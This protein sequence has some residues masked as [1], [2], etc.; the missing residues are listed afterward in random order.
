MRKKSITVLIKIRSWI[1]SLIVVIFIVYLT[2]ATVRSVK[3][4]ILFLKKDRIN[5]VFYGKQTV[6]LS[7][8]LTD[9]VHYQIPFANNLLL[10]IPG[11]YG[12]YKVGSLGKLSQ[13]EKNPTLIQ[14]TFSSATASFVDFDFFPKKTEIYSTNQS[15]V[16]INTLLQLLFSP[17]YQS[18]ASFFERVMLFTKLVSI[19]TS[20]LIKIDADR[21]VSGVSFSEKDFA[22][23]YK[24]YFYQKKLR[25]E[26]KNIRLVYN[27]FQ[28]A[29]M[30]NRILEGEGIRVVDFE[31][32]PS[33]DKITAEKCI[34]KDRFIRGKASFTGRYLA[35]LFGCIIEN[36][37]KNKNLIFTL[38]DKLE[39]QWE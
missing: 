6:F 20:D 19:R 10:Q 12:R 17:R 2:Y 37:T 22:N 8:G 39:D 24:G 26:A 25:E 36:Q 30:L 33:V 27:K 38:S 5:V 28:A 13:L 1:I 32:K 35:K 15:V 7:L 14:K 34:I 31:K 18:R 11:G 21:F 4:S 29:V 9:G 3:N 16:S 23:N